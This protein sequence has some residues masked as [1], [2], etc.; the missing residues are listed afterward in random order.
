MSLFC[1]NISISKGVDCTEAAELA[2]LFLGYL[3]LYHPVASSL[4]QLLFAYSTAPCQRRKCFPQVKGAS[5][6]C[7]VLGLHS[8]RFLLPW[9]PVVFVPVFSSERTLAVAVKSHLPHRCLFPWLHYP[10]LTAES[11]CSLACLPL[12]RED[13]GFAC[14]FTSVLF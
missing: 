10:C 9:I 2:V 13:G 14:Y 11:V 8:A 12:Y 3:P 6:F 4:F 7:S 1:R 5:Y